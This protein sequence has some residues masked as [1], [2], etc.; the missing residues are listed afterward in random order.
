MASGNRSALSQI[1]HDEQNRLQKLKRSIQGDLKKLVLDYRR[2][3]SHSRDLRQEVENTAADLQKTR[4]QLRSIRYD[5]RTQQKREINLLNLLLAGLKDPLDIIEGHAEEL[6]AARETLR[7][8]RLC[9]E[10]RRLRRIV[11]DLMA[12]STV[13]LGNAQMKREKVDVRELVERVLEEH[14]QA[15]RGQQVGLDGRFAGPIPPVLG[16]RQQLRLALN[17]LVDNAITHSPVGETVTVEANG[18]HTLNRVQ[19][20]IIDRR[21]D[22]IDE[23]M[24]EFLWSSAPEEKWFQKGI[25]GFDLELM[26]AAHLIDL[27]NG[28][29]D[30]TSR[31]GRETILTLTLPTGSL[32]GGAQ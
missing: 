28:R 9:S 18:K 7:P 5:R 30:I 24:M 29:I 8:D 3:E 22:A 31:P 26:A 27:L 13:Q 4:S 1:D 21:P 11:T 12:A 20:T 6:A 23:Q 16:D 19:V 17:H 2:M 15:A 25:R 32:A 10:V 14:R